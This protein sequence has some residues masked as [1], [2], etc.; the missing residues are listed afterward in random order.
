MIYM[1][2]LFLN[3]PISLLLLPFS[4]PS[5]WSE[6]GCSSLCYG[7]VGQVMRMYFF[8]HLLFARHRENRAS[9]GA[10]L[11]V[12]ELDGKHVSKHNTL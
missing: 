4:Q 12:R 5:L 11:L 1:N 10:S 6:C 7:N 9:P 8:K 3:Q 2:K